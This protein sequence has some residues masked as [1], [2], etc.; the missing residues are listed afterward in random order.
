MHSEGFKFHREVTDRKTCAIACP[1]AQQSRTM[2]RYRRHDSI[3][4]NC[5]LRSTVRLRMSILGEDGVLIFLG[6]T[7]FDNYLYLFVTV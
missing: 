6:G 1:V 7:V 5:L 4:M 3:R 2:L